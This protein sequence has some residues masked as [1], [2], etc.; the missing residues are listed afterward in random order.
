MR[1]DE[2]S[3]D[4]DLCSNSYEPKLPDIVAGFEV[5]GKIDS[6]KIVA[7]NRKTLPHLLSQDP[8][9]TNVVTSVSRLVHLL[10]REPEIGC[11]ESA[12]WKGFP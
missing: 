6:H 1:C 10:T 9:E 11:N 8:I 2:Q 4:S 3:I 5:L 12:R 7:L